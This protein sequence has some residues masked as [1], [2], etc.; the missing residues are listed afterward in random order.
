MSGGSPAR[1]S[2]H[3][4][5]IVSP[6]EPRRVRLVVN[7]IG[8]GERHTARVDAVIQIDKLPCGFE[9][10]ITGVEGVDQIG[11]SPCPKA[12][13]TCSHS[14][15]CFGTTETTRERRSS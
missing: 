7:P 1:Q 2:K 8:A 13:R 6:R 4:S 14:T 3:V 9:S 12:R 15:S 5:E 10:L 11:V